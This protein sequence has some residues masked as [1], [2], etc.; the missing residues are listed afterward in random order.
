MAV[1]GD[2]GTTGN[3]VVFKL[4]LMAGLVICDVERRELEASG[5]VFND[6]NPTDDKGDPPTSGVCCLIESEGEPEDE[7]DTVFDLNGCTG[8]ILGRR[9]GSGAGAEGSS[10]LLR[11]V[12]LSFRSLEARPEGARLDESKPEN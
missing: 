5:R 8:L 2:G 9:I 3:L 7:V 11:P 10:A 1:I 6:G 12:A 4:V